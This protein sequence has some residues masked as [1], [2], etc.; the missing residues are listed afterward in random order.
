MTEGLD[1]GL[2]SAGLITDFSGL[3]VGGGFTACLVVDEGLVDGF[4]SLAAGLE[5]GSAGLIVGLVVD[6]GSSAGCFVVNGSAGLAAGF[7]GLVTGSLSLAVGFSGC[8]F[9]VDFSAAG[10]CE[11]DLTCC[12]LAVSDIVGFSGCC[13]SGGGSGV[14]G[15][16]GLAVGL[17]GVVRCGLGFVTDSGLVTLGIL[18]LSSSLISLSLKFW[19]SCLNPLSFPS[20]K[21]LS[22]ITSISLRTFLARSV[23]L[24]V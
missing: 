14:F 3:V 8:G 13:L 15:F 20:P 18:C 2:G 10:G 4:S 24:V 6:G 16:S 9:A 5:E 17:L 19:A 12:G 23:F 7:S 1:A 22:F 11:D 21:N